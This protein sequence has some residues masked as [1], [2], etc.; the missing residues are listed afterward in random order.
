MFLKKQL[1]WTVIM[2]FQEAAL[3]LIKLPMAATSTD[4]FTIKTKDKGKTDTVYQRLCVSQLTA[5]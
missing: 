1:T 2:L 5:M 4:F 3:N